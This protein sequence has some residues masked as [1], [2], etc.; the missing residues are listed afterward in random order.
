MSPIHGGFFRYTLGEFFGGVEDIAWEAPDQLLALKRFEHPNLQ[1]KRRGLTE[2]QANAWAQR[3]IGKACAG[4]RRD[5][6]CTAVEIRGAIQ[7]GA[8]TRRSRRQG[9]VVAA[10]DADAPTAREWEALET[11]LLEATGAEVKTACQAGEID[12]RRLM[13]RVEE[14]IQ[15]NGLY[16]LRSVEQ[17][18]MR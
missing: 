15:R 1:R 5:L 3:R 6:V 11:Y 8:F 9:V 17:W 4:L 13:Q 10:I 12:L 7:R 18:L 2:A 16:G 14:M